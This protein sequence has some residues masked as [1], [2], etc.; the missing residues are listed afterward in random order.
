MEFEHKI[1]RLNVKLEGAL[2]RLGRKQQEVGEKW[3]QVRKNRCLELA[4]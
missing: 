1:K 3:T 4:V 2:F